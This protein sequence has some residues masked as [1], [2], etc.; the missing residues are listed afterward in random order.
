MA[1]YMHRS[2]PR[3]T[4]KKVSPLKRAGKAG[5]RVMH[6]RLISLDFFSRNWVGVAISVL[7]LVWY[8]TNKYECRT[9]MERV[10]QLEKQLEIVKGDYINEHSTYMSS[11]REGAMEELARR[12]HLN[13]RVQ[14]EPPFKLSYGSD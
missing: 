12:N 4:R 13:L 3:G 1:L 8:I 5:R 11:I 9:S 7:L 14:D 10:Q 6:G 2:E